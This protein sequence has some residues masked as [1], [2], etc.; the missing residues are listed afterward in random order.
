MTASSSDEMAG[1][2][3]AYQTQVLQGVSRTFALTIPQLPA[4]LRNVVGNAYLLCRTTDAIEDEPALSAGQKQ[5]FAERFIDIV[6][7]RA[8]MEP[9]ARELGA[10]LSAST[11]AQRT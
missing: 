4:A 7:G 3:L 1:G 6:A 8:A 9:F 5:A 10:G 11:T 2:D